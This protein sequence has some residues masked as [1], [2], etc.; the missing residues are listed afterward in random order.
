MR[1]A[2]AIA[3]R[4]GWHGN[5]VGLH[6]QPPPRGEAA[7][8]LLPRPRLCRRRSVFISRP[9]SPPPPRLLRAL[10]QRIDLLER[11]ARLVHPLS[12]STV[13]LFISRFTLSRIGP[14][15]EIG[16]FNRSKRLKGW[17]RLFGR[18]LLLP[19]SSCVSPIVRQMPASVQLITS[20]RCDQHQRCSASTAGAGLLYVAGLHRRHRADRVLRLILDPCDSAAVAR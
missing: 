19:S 20:A 7:V 18:P 15:P 8:M 5:G 12:S 9:T 3:A 16:L 4:A 2:G 13:R 17:A 10:V 1:E 14:A 6:Q 11:A